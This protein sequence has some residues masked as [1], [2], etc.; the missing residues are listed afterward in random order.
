[1]KET[2]AKRLLL[3]TGTEPVPNGV[4]GI[5]LDDLIRVL[6]KASLVISHVVDDAE[7]AALDPG[8]QRSAV[9]S[10]R[11]FSIDYRRRLN[12]RW[13]KVGRAVRSSL[14]S[15]RNRQQVRQ[16]MA[17]SV[18]FARG[19]AV[20]AVWAVLDTPAVIEMA[21]PLAHAL[22]VPLYAMVWDDVEHNI[23]YFGLDRMTAARVRRRFE[24]AVG[25]CAGLAVIG[26]TMQSAYHQR[27]G[28][29][30]I[31]VRHGVDSVPAVPQQERAGVR[32]GFAGSV[33]AR[34][35]FERL[36]AALDSLGWEIDSRPVTLVLM[37]PR[38]DL[39]SRVPRRVECL[40]WRSVPET[41]EILSGCTVNYLP[42]PFEPD[43]RAFSELSFPS[44][45]TTYL[46][47]GVP[48]LL[49]A[50]AYASLP[51]YL[52]AQ[53]FAE[54]CSELDADKLAGSLRQ[55]VGDR[56]LR[57]GVTEGAAR[58]LANDFCSGT[59]L[60][61]FSEF[62]RVDLSAGRSAPAQEGLATPCAASPAS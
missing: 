4:G 3:L 49:H 10:H 9:L 21:A 14:H 1:M 56:V 28:K 40:G 5:I 31:I 13:G 50:P 27:Y 16:G 60:K 6:P 42:Q 55:L 2:T 53:P 19:H 7:A 29:R 26:E 47:A 51:G 62:L 41:I 45:L 24:D 48:I 18:A 37:G 11:R 22:G 34:S 52:P 39:W 17:G 61:S 54:L 15:L 12:A 33:T 57:S 20:D 32:I 36:L 30:G 59:F 25:G 58:A 35:A 43:W 46:A 23:R 8:D 44:K 38:F